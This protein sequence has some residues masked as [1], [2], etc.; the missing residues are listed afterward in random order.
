M[1]VKILIFHGIPLSVPMG[2]VPVIAT[3]ETQAAQRKIVEASVAHIFKSMR[4]KP[5]EKRLEIMLAEDFSMAPL[6]QKMAEENK[7]DLIV[8]GTKG[9]TGAKKVLFGSNTVDVIS[10]THLPVLA[11][12]QHHRYKPIRKIVMPSDLKNLR[13]E[14]KEVLPFAKLFNANV[15]ILF[16]SDA[17]EEAMKRYNAGMKVVKKNFYRKIKLSIEGLH[18]GTSV[19]KNIESA[20][21][22]M[23]PDLLVM[24]RHEHNWLANLFLTSKTDQL[25]FAAKM[26][27]LALREPE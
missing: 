9:A 16:L 21:K 6:I 4:F 19:S 22:K 5:K 27:L 1:D 24:F 18:Y 20:M 10:R 13:K 26:P 7:A 12:A 14:L 2:D 8:M 15:E 25:A 11:V 23:K 17:S 3:P